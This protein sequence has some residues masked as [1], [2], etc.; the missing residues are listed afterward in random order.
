MYSAIKIYSLHELKCLSKIRRIPI[1]RI[2]G[3]WYG[4]QFHIRKQN[5]NG[6]EQSKF[7]ISLFRLSDCWFIAK[8]IFAEKSDFQEEI[9]VVTKFF[10]YVSLVHYS[11]PAKW[12]FATVFAKTELEKPLY[13][14]AWGRWLPWYSWQ[15]RISCIK[16]NCLFFHFIKATN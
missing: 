12:T 10:P 1:S 4:L 8:L 5:I 3:N 11:T 2:H 13:H 14:N 7:F 9:A 16:F 6:E 15:M